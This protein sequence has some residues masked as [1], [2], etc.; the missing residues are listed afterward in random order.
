M[1]PK[2]PNGPLAALVDEKLNSSLA[3]QIA[4]EVREKSE[5]SA[6]SGASDYAHG[7][8]EHDDDRDT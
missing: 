2:E 3:D 1:Q 5:E 6:R 7:T 4:E 8:A